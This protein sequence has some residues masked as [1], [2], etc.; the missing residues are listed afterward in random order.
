M[1]EKKRETNT[2]RRSPLMLRG[3][4]VASPLVA[5]AAVLALAR[6][7][8]LPVYLWSSGT[9]RMAVILCA[10][11]VSLLIVIA[12]IAHGFNVRQAT[13]RKLISEHEE[14]EQHARENE[15][16]Y[17]VLF[18]DAM[19]TAYTDLDRLNQNLREQKDYLQAKM[20][21]QSRTSEELRQSEERW[22]QLVERNPEGI[23]I[24]RGRRI[25]YGNGVAVSLVTDR[26]EDVIDHSVLEF[27]PPDTWTEA[28]RLLRER[29][30]GIDADPVQLPIRAVNG[31]SRW[32]EAY[33]VPIKYRGKAAVQTVIRDVTQRR[34]AEYEL[35]KYTERIAA[36]HLIAQGIL[37]DDSPQVV[38]ENAL[39]HLRRLIPL[40][41]AS[42]IEIDLVKGEGKMMILGGA[43]TVATLRDADHG[44]IQDFGCTPPD[45]HT[46][47]YLYY[48]TVART[49][50]GMSGLESRMFV[51]GVRSYIELPLVIKGEW[52]GVIHIGSNREG[53]FTEDDCNVAVD[54]AKMIAVSMHQERIEA[55]RLG[56]ETELLTAKEHAEQMAR[57]KT[58]FLT[59]M[60][61]EIR[62]P[63][64]G[65]IGFAQILSEEIDDEHSEFVNLIEQ[66]GRRLLDTINSVLD[67]ARLESNRM[68]MSLEPVRVTEEVW[69]TTRLLKPL[70]DRK[71]LQLR[72]VA[73]GDFVCRLDRTGFGRILNN[74]IGNAIK[75]TETGGVTVHVSED[76]EDCR[77]DVTD[78]GVGIGS[79]FLPLLF[80]EF[81]QESSG[82]DRS[83][84]GSGMGLS[85]TRK[86]TDIMGGTISVKSAK[87]HG[88]TF[89]V[90][91][92]VVGAES[93]NGDR[94]PVRSVTS[95]SEIRGTHRTS[96]G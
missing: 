11:V 40:T 52:V 39:G 38:A 57:L 71:N 88:S 33:S 3:A 42:V 29:F 32:I 89:S 93:L 20:D 5:A 44:P 49:V 64:T 61:H 27:L 62:T 87:G 83:H 81:R 73:A 56:Y 24:T 14:R 47:D 69:R 16:H 75:F 26:P 30:D 19:Q 1:L 13:L 10:S 2:E 25:L 72:V 50:R 65:I 31:A 86:L 60:S 70:A 58:T 46:P 80:D 54:I 6:F 18:E 91:F 95:A 41:Y 67:L 9:V 7:G 34:K 21:E 59:N 74:L 68:R 23:I 53:G 35:L 84:E 28:E 82:A 37:S 78:T 79:D 43:D 48:P 85:I 45:N 12:V 63:L 36:L 17:R 96:D 77:I 8:L 4:A 15:R 55:E 92:P 22:R 94:P 90:A 66:S 51:A 76:G